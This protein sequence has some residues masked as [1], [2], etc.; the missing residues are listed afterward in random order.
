MT[1]NA[2]NTERITTEDVRRLARLTYLDPPADQLEQIKSDLGGILSAVDQL[3][4]VDTTNVE[5]LASVLEDTV[6]KRR[7]DVSPEGVYK[8]SRTKVV[9]ANATRKA[10]PFFAVPKQKDPFEGDF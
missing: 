10:G 8:E 6:L 1:K 3:Q 9:L 4:R 5:P 2:S 7:Q